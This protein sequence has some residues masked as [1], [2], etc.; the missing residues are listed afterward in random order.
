M[1]SSTEFLASL[2]NYPAAYE[3]DEASN[4]AQTK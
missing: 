2:S 3:I 1:N 4:E